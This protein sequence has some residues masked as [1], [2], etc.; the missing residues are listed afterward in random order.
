[1]NNGLKGSQ[2]QPHEIVDK[3][4][5][6]SG[7]VTS[8]E[9]RV[10]EARWN[11]LWRDVVTQPEAKARLDGLAFPPTRMVPMADTSPSMTGIPVIVSIALSLGVS[12]ITHP[13]IRDIILT[14]SS[15]PTWHMLN[16]SD[17]IVQKE[18][19]PRRVGRKD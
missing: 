13:A 19:E 6:A 3:I 15:E 7:I 8:I 1:V 9:T 11:D 2:Q 17:S 16:P 18:L 4:V 10:I 5:K 14:F 12:E